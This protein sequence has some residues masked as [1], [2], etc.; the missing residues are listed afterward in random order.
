M[1]VNDELGELE[2]ALAGG[3]GLLKVGGRMAVITVESLTDRMVKRFFAAHEGRM[4]SLQG[5]GERWTGETP[6]VRRVTRR[7]VRASQDEIARNPRARSAKLGTVERIG[8]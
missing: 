5:G 4:S 7:A 1:A 6:R 8:E 2:R 3:I